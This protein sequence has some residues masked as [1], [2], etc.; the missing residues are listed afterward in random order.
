[1][2]RLIQVIGQYHAQRVYL[3]LG[4]VAS[5]VFEP[6]IHGRVAKGQEVEKANSVGK[7]GKKEGNGDRCK[8]EHKSRID[9]L[10][11]GNKASM[12]ERDDWFG[13]SH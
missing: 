3:A 1:M 8:I 6:K 5:S 10:K 7:R 4:R 9:E 12:T 11:E 13:L 2:A